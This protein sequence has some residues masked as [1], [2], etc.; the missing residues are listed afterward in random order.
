MPH[1][2]KGF[3]PGEWREHIAVTCGAMA[4]TG[5]VPELTAPEWR[6]IL[7]SMDANVSQIDQ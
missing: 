2:A 1:G 6:I 4:E 3:E 5:A 7:L